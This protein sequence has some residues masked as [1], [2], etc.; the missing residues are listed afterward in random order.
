MHDSF[1]TEREPV[2]AWAVTAGVGIPVSADTRL[3]LAI[4]YGSRGSTD[5]SMIKDTIL[6][7]SASITISELWFSR[8]EED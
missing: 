5:K 6:R 4:E 2:N 7:F 8:F 3:N 1:R